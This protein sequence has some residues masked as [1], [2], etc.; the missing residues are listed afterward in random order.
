MALANVPHVQFTK[1]ELAF[2]ALEE[3]E[4]AADA[5]LAVAI[6][7]IES[8]EGWS[9]AYLNNTNGTQDSGWLQVNEIWRDKLVTAGKIRFLTDLFDPIVCLRAA[10]WI[11]S[12]PRTGWGPWAYGP[13]SYKQPARTDTS[14]NLLSAITAVANPVNPYWKMFDAGVDVHD[15]PRPPK[16][17]YVSDLPPA[18]LKFGDSGPT[19]HQLQIVLVALGLFPGVTDNYYGPR[20]RGDTP[21]NIGGGVREVQRRLTECGLWFAPTDGIYSTQLRTVWDGARRFSY[22]EK[23]R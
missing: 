3:G 22:M 13:Y 15:L 18:S 8:G 17:T 2:I 6:G 23:G 21:Q 10:Q 14:I 5:A 16:G 11:R 20:V 19:V 4:T 12:Q 1:N 7:W 9:N